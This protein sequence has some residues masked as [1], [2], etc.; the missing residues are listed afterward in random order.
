MLAVLYRGYWWAMTAGRMEAPTVHLT[1]T[2]VAV[3]SNWSEDVDVLY[4]LK[5]VSLSFD[6]S[7]T[8]IGNLNYSIFSCRISSSAFILCLMRTLFDTFLYCSISGFS[9]EHFSTS[10]ATKLTAGTGKAEVSFIR[11][12]TS[13]TTCGPGRVAFTDLFTAV[14][15][16]RALEILGDWLIYD[17]SDHQ[18]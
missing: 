14:L 6:I 13:M 12:A 7:V 4:D 11:V 2:Y 1:T 8:G 3:I 9:R 16:R 18:H 10:F 17:S 5:F 15:E